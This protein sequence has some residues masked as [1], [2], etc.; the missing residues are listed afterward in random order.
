MTLENPNGGVSSAAETFID[1]QRLDI[2]VPATMK[3]YALFSIGQNSE[4]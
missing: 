2:Q 1:M 3:T 4:S